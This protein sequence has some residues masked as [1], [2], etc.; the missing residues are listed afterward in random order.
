MFHTL[1]SPATVFAAASGR[2]TAKTVSVLR[3]IAA[4]KPSPSMG[5]WTDYHMKC[6]TRKK[7]D[8]LAKLV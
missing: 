4:K 8:N 7:K 3:G 1:P 5:S 2:D 6:N